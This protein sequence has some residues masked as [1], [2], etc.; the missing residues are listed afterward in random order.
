MPRIVVKKFKGHSGAEINLVNDNG[1]LVV[2]K[3][4]LGIKRNFD[5][6][7]KLSNILNLPKILSFDSNVLT[8]EYINGIDMIHYVINENL[9][10]LI[11]FL[12]STYSTLNSYIINPAKD[13]LPVYEEKLYSVEWLPATVGQIIDTLP[14]YL[15]QTLYHGDL[16]MSNILYDYN[17]S[18]FVLIDAVTTPFDSV[19]FDISKLRQD[20]DC[21]WFIRDQQLLISNKLFLIREHLASCCQYYK[22]NSMAILSLLRVWSHSNAEEKLWLSKKIENLWKTQ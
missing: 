20:I 14:R 15:P 5:Q 21:E 4:G 19:H 18:R 17:N 3:T 1:V 13:Y 7:N 8:M 11:N 12:K 9:M 6:I 2:A 10:L 22:N 16:T